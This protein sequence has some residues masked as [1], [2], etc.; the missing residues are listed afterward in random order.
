M[1]L[2]HSWPLN[3]LAIALACFLPARSDSFVEFSLPSDDSYLNFTSLLSIAQP[4]FTNLLSFDL[5]GAVVSLSSPVQIRTVPDTWAT[6]NSPPFTESPTPR[7][8]FSNQSNTL[9]M[10]FSKPY[11]IFGFEAEPESLGVSVVSVSFFNGAVLVGS[12]SQPVDGDGG[13]MLFAALT[14]GAFTRVTV[15]APEDT[16]FA[17]AQVRATAVP[18][19]SMTI[20]FAIA[21]MIL[22][23]IKTRRVLGRQLSVYCSKA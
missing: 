18:E 21:G 17:M 1:S 4:D 14:D 5:A 20:V 19:P 23:G 16:G 12:I 22:L 10:D 6:W 3:M 7:V 15:S 2:P 11:S 9:T 8:L 13:A